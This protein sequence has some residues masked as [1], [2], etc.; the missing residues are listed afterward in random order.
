M[1]PQPVAVCCVMFVEGD[2]FFVIF[3]GFDPKMTQ[4]IPLTH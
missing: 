2:T 1:K 3:D 4:E